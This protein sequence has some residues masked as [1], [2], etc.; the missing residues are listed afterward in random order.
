MLHS[1]SE[2]PVDLSAP[3]TPAAEPRRATVARP[4]TFKSLVLDRG[5]G[6]FTTARGEGSST[7]PDPVSYSV[8]VE[9]GLEVAPA[10]FAEAVDAT[11]AD[12]RGWRGIAEHEFQRV[13]Q[14]QEVRVLLATPETVDVLCAPLQTDGEVSCRNQDR[15]VINAKR[16]FYGAEPF[17]RPLREYRRYVI[18]HEVGHALGYGHQ[19]CPEPGGVAPVMLQ[20]TL[21]LD[22]CTANPWPV[23][24][25]PPDE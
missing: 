23:A 22:G 10:D 13:E 15:V 1:S 2:V 7:G 18:N 20:Q 25:P 8:E 21:G 6:H 5:T 12:S 17:N 3:R 9:G 24:G 14:G 11:L 16:W 19:A 4:M